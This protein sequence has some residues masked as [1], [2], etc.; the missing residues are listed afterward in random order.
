MRDRANKRNRVPRPAVGSAL[1]CNNVNVT[2]A[3]RMNAQGI[4][5]IFWAWGYPCPRSWWLVLTL[6]HLPKGKTQVA[7]SLRRIGSKEETSLAVIDKE[8]DKDDTITTVPIH[9]N[10]SFTKP[11]RYELLCEVK[12]VDR[13]LRIPFVVLEKEWIHFSPEEQE[14]VRNHPET[15]HT[16]RANVHCKECS[17]AYIFEES[18]IDDEPPGGVHR[19]PP[20]GEFKCGNCGAKLELRDVQGR[21]RA[22]LHDIVR[23]AMERDG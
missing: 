23:K 5:T 16:L 14:F 3:G 12:R 8:S 19:F 15:P 4:I 6:F 9:L 20:S 10:H 7:I 18:V 11:G 2:D 17:Y 21:L 22:S 13:K 1:L